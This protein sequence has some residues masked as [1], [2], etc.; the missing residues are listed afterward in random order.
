MSLSDRDI[1]DFRR[2]FHRIPEAG[3]MEFQTTIEIIDILK[4]WGYQLEYGKAIH[5]EERMGLPS[6]QETED[7]LAT[8]E[9]EADY[10]I[11]EI[12]EG[13]TG[14]LARLDTKRDGPTIALRFDIDALNIQESQDEEHLPKREG[15]SSLN[16]KTMHACG[17]D[18]HIAIGLSLAS[19]LMDNKDKLRGNFILIFQPAEEGVRGARSMVEAG[20]V[21]NVDYLLGG[22]IGLGGGVGVLGVGTG[23]FL[24]TSKMDISFEGV[25]SHAGAS[26]EE[27]KNALLAAA[28]CTL[29][30]YSLPQ[31][32]RGMSRLNVGVLKAGSS[33]N[34]VANQAFMQIETRGENE[35][36]NQMLAKKVDQVIQ[37]AAKSFD[38]D[39]KV[40]LVGSAPAYSVRDRLFTQEIADYLESAGYQVDTSLR[41]GGSEDISYMFNEVEDGG[42]KALHFTFGTDISA[43]HHHYRFDFDEGV[44]LFARN[45]LRDTLLYLAGI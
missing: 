32:G 39:Y 3:W 25:P 24:A 20:V 10:D 17:H 43:P 22:H 33:R 1:R 34:I 21:D 9:L 38:V 18:G 44:L 11:S 8:L 30:L 41:L 5:G 13:Y 35:E 26:P 31:F 6:R 36:I 4:S 16:P 40:E 15:F 37:G 27:G 2:K 29:N 23:G 12:L 7:Y 45:A 14:V 28:S 42:G 19:W